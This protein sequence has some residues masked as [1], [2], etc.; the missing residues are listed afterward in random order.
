MPCMQVNSPP[1]ECL[2]RPRWGST[3]GSQHTPS[4]SSSFRKASNRASRY[5]SSLMTYSTRRLTTAWGGGVSDR[6]RRSRPTGSRLSI[7]RS[8]V[9]VSSRRPTQR[10]ARR[11]SRKLSRQE[12]S[13]RPTATRA[14]R[15]SSPPSASPSQTFPPRKARRDL[16]QK[17]RRGLPKKGKGRAA[18]PLA[19]LPPCTPGP[20]PGGRAHAHPRTCMRICTCPCGPNKRSGE[21]AIN[22]AS[23]CTPAG[24]GVT[25][26]GAERQC[27]RRVQCL[28]AQGEGAC[29][30]VCLSA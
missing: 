8:F 1:E 24:A 9:L 30:Y 7:S 25:A 13:L 21:R 2:V 12:T 20:V 10:L 5:A 18:T 22:E 17:A 3:R 14:T 4:A 23:A 28:A 11:H 15:R 19:P 6:R 29:V 27:E 26:C 16:P